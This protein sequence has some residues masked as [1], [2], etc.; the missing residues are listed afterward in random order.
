MYLRRPS[1]AFPSSVHTKTKDELFS[2]VSAT[3]SAYLILLD[4]I[5]QAVRSEEYKHYTSAYAISRASCYCPPG[6]AWIR[7]TWE[8]GLCSN[9]QIYSSLYEMVM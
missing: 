9:Q 8:V 2:S 4:L 7:N 5:T 3:Y 6:I 1:G